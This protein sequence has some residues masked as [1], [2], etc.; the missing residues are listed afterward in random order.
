MR[1]RMI[2][3]KEMRATDLAKKY[4]FRYLTKNTNGKWDVR[5]M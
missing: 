3:W 4:Q 2:N 5:N 1:K